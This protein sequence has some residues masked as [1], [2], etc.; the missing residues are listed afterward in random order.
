MD[1]RPM[2]RSGEHKVHVRHAN[3]SSTRTGDLVRVLLE[4]CDVRVIYFND[5][6]LIREFPK[7]KKSRGHNDHLHVRLRTRERKPQALGNTAREP[8]ATR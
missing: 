2:T 5:W 1:L 8:V 7:V 3:Y 4:S 6:R